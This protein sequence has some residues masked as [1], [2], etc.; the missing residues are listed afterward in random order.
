MNCFYLPSIHRG[1]CEC[2]LSPQYNEKV[3]QPS[4]ELDFHPE[5]SVV[6][7]KLLWE[8][9]SCSGWKVVRMA[10]HSR[11]AWAGPGRRGRRGR[12]GS[13]GRAQHPFSTCDMSERAL[14]AGDKVLSKTQLLTPQN[15]CSSGCTKIGK[16]ERPGQRQG[17]S[18]IVTCRRVCMGRRW[19]GSETLI[20]ACVLNAVSILDTHYLIKVAMKQRY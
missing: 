1:C 8:A 6:C 17:L 18:Y 5:Q 3:T 7:A 13:A 2:L 10:C 19:G 16:W 14:S 11:V 12:K 4:R 20:E 9:W 15:L